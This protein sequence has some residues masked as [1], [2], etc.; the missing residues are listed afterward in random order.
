M[1]SAEQITASDANGLALAANNSAAKLVGKF[2][3]L[4]SLDTRSSLDDRAV[5]RALPVVLDEHEVLER[6]SPKSKSTSTGGLAIEVMA[7]FLDD[8]T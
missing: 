6:L 1:T 3:E 5:I 2:I 7:R 8:D 4:K